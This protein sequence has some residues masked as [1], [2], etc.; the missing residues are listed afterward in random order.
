MERATYDGLQVRLRNYFY[1]ALPPFL[2][3]S[4]AGA[5]L[6]CCLHELV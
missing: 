5:E 6:Q 1:L 3:E 2:R 4:L